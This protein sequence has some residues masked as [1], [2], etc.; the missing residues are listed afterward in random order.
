LFLS[1]VDKK[2]T[3]TYSRYIVCVRKS[4]S[5]NKFLIKENKETIK[6]EQTKEGT[7]I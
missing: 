5:E 6:K 2:N 1:P 7:K 3:S 4:M